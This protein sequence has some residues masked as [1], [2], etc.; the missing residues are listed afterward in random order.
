MILNLVVLHNMFDLKEGCVK[1]LL[2]VHRVLWRAPGEIETLHF[3]SV[4]ISTSATCINFYLEIETLFVK[5]WIF[6]S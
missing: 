3:S 4:F 6:E 1:R 2:Y 5:E